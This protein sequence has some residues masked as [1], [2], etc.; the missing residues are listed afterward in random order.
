MKKALD[1]Y[2]LIKHLPVLSVLRKGMASNR[3]KGTLRP[4]L[5]NLSECFSIELGLL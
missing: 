2:G 1:P 3:I 4:E 5:G